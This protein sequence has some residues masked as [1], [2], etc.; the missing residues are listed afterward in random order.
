MELGELLGQQMRTP[1]GRGTTMCDGNAKPPHAEEEGRL[2]CSGIWGGIQDLDQDISAGSIVA[3]VY[4][5]S[6]DGGKG[7]DIYYIGAC[8]DCAITRVA[9]ADVMGHGQAVSDGSQYVYDS[10]KAH[11]CD[12]DSGA[13]LPEINRLASE[14]GLKAMTTAAVVT[15]SAD[16]GEVRVSYA[17]HPPVLLKRVNGQAWSSLALDN[18]RDQGDD[19]DTGFPLAV[20]AD[21]VYSERMIPVASGDRLFVYTDGVIEARN[22]KGE[23]FGSQRLIEVLEANADASLSQLKSAVVQ[24]LHRYT[25]NGLK[26]DDVTLIAME[27]R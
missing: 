21:A 12:P 1:I 8:R 20:A 6:C 3:S 23:L 10:L 17:G 24:A 26:H 27:V 16:K 9:I 22:G 7:G 11:I 18:D 2:A 13:I 4:S 15:Y 25:G 14:R 5:S 19:L